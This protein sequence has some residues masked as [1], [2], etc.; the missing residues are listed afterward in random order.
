MLA[1]LARDGGLYVPE[2]WPRLEPEEIAGFAG[3]SYA[4][5]AVAVIRPFIG[6]S[7]PEADLARMAREAYG[8]FRHPAVAPLD[9]ARREHLHARIVSRPDARL[10]G[11]GD[12]A[13]GAADGPCARRAR[14]APHHRGRHLR[15]YRRRC[16]RGVPRPQP[17]RPRRAVSPW[18]HFRSAA[19]HDDHGGG[20][21]CQ[22]HR[23]R[24]HLRRLSGH[25][26]RPVQSSRLSRP[27][28]LVRR[29][30]HQLG[31]HR[32]AGGLLLHRRGLARRASA[33]SRLHRSD[34]QFRR[35]LCRLRGAAFGIADRPAGYRHQRQR[36]PHPHAIDR[37]LR[38]A[39]RRG[40]HLAV[41]GHPGRLEFRAAVVRC[42]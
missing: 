14:R 9:A 23:H 7:I 32:R 16:R 6:D 3:R 12:A 34:R 27:S 20:R 36:Y 25:R 41:D 24:R 21:Q 19:A 8:S 13:S 2:A 18:P 30:F 40:D 28:A 11:S 10:Q 22:R 42:L 37:R 4:E 35:H 26:E 39:R 33:Q 31:A 5:V 38:A 17:G 15:R 1:G 29:Q